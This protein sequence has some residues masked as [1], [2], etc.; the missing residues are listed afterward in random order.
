VAE[1]SERI[2]SS[3][4][5]FRSRALDRGNFPRLALFQVRQG[6]K[7]LGDTKMLMLGVARRHPVGHG[8]SF[9]CLPT[10]I[11]SPVL[12]SDIQRPAFLCL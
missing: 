5:R 10:I 3:E 9:L 7:V 2:A 11:G 4:L 12:S 8:T 1:V 6:L